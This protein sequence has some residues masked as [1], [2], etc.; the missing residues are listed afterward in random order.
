MDYI[1]KTR[2]NW[3]ILILDRMLLL[4]KE[5]VWTGF[6]S[7]WHW[8]SSGFHSS[9][10]PLWNPEKQPCQPAKKPD[11]DKPIHPSSFLKN[12]SISLCIT[13]KI[14]TN[15][16]MLLVSRA[17]FKF[18]MYS[19]I[20]LMTQ[21]DQE[22]VVRVFVSILLL[23][24]DDTMSSSWWRAFVQSPNYTQIPLEEQHVTMIFLS[25]FCPI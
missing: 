24:R 7:D 17:V 3:K 12:I 21:R 2:R 13:V 20:L 16:T 10:W 1:L 14:F 18:E 11:L 9:L 4:K 15:Y 19:R 23:V 8:S 6:S 25:V 5:S 22:A